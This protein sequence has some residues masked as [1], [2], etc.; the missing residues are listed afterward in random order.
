MILN[1]IL[2]SDLYKFSMQNAVLELFPDAQVE[3]K[4]KNRGNQR[5]NEIFLDSLKE[6]IQQMSLLK[7]RDDE[8]RWLKENC[9]YLKRWYLEYL[10]N[11]VYDPNQVKISLDDKNDL[12]LSINGPWHETILYEVPLMAIISEL[13]FIHCEPDWGI[14]NQKSWMDAKF[15]RLYQNACIWADFG[16]RRRRSYHVQD[17]L[18]KNMSQNQN[19]QNLISKRIGFVGTSNVHL[20][21]KY[22]VKP[23]GTCAHEWTQGMQILNSLNHCNYYAMENWIKVFSKVEIGTVLTDTIGVDA[24]LRDFNRKMSML[25]P[26]VR[27]DSGCPFVF[28]DKIIKHYKKMKIDPKEKTIIFSDG[29]NVDK[30]IEINNYCK[31]RIKCSF[32]IGTFFTNSFEN[33]P[34][35]NMVIKLW[36]VNNQFVIK[37]S[38]VEGKENGHPKMI[39]IMKWIIKNQI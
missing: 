35:L 30:T 37:I 17:I 29:L 12:A 28:T 11:Y 16:T 31:D 13:Y 9:P 23:I 3:Y 5:F 2:D 7:L 15:N 21:M 4:F 10:K 27:H 1:S 19:K 36:S 20:S 34:A 38:D 22:G 18:V 32:G 24:F 14:Q 8:Y 39:E 33:S 26:S 6:N 25:Y